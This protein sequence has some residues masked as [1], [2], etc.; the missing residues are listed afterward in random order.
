ML[1]AAASVVLLLV[2]TGWWAVRA[3]QRSEM[4]ELLQKFAPIGKPPLEIQFPA[5]LSGSAET[6]LLLAP[7]AEADFW[8]VR[9]SSSGGPLEVRVTRNGQRYFSAVGNRIVAGFG[10]GTRS[11]TGIDEITDTPPTRRVKFRYVWAEVHPALIFLGDGSPVTG[12]EYAGDAMLVRVGEN[13]TLAHWTTPEFDAAQKQFQSLT[14]AA[15]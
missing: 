12:K 13:W 6:R 9:G 8:M 4:I 3:N 7:G 10:A 2:G 11:I 15:R 1:L 5:T 14:S